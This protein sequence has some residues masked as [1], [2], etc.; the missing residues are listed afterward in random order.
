MNI[1]QMYWKRIL[2]SRIH[3]FFMLVVPVV[4]TALTLMAL[5]GSGKMAVAWADQD[6]TPFTRSLKEY[7]GEHARLIPMEEDAIHAQLVQLRVQ[8][9]VVLP[10]GLTENIIDHGGA[11]VRGLGIQDSNVYRPFAFA[12]D[13]ALNAAVLL[14]DRALGE[15]ELFYGGWNSYTGGRFRVEEAAREGRS[16]D[17]ST[18][19]LGFLIMSMLFLSNFSTLYLVRDRQTR[20]VMRILLAPVSLRQYMARAIASFLAVSVLQVGLVLFVLHVVLDFDLG[21]QPAMVAAVLA[22]FAVV[23]V[24]L[25]VGVSNYVPSV[26]AAS[27]ISSLIIMPMC[28]LGGC[29][30][31]REIMPDFLQQISYFVPTT[32]AM[33]GSM[34]AL[35]GH[36]LAAVQTEMLFL[37]LFAAVFFLLGSWKKLDLVR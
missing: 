19:S 28:M 15:K 20:T 4:L 29:F 8:Y 18:M 31:P 37:A 1:I 26:Q 32:W 14:A 3:L 23:G 12:L 11:A 30:W 22:A 34:E 7:L 9:A 33:R 16:L 27:T 6:Q 24:A 5:G 35:G 2:K 17:Q 21:P 36:G 25:G 10:E 13:N